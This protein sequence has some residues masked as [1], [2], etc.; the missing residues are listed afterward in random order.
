MVVTSNEI[1]DAGNILFRFAE[2]LEVFANDCA[3]S[4][5]DVF[6]ALEWASSQEPVQKCAVHKK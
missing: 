2:I 3:K 6:F 4:N 1:R 5:C